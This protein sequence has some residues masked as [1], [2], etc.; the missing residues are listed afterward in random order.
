MKGSPRPEPSRRDPRE[1]VVVIDNNHNGA[2]QRAVAAAVGALSRTHAEHPT[3]EV[4]GGSPG[5]IPADGA[6]LVI[7]SAAAVD[8]GMLSQLAGRGALIAT[9]SRLYSGET[10]T[11]V[12][13]IAWLRAGSRGVVES[14][15]L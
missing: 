9:G 6:K 15:A 2:L 11:A 13:T 14:P 7:A 10:P 8:A 3:L 5:A 12:D 4:I 1:L